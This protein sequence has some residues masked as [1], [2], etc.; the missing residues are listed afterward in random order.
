MGQ[1]A[2]AVDYSNNLLVVSARLRA[3]RIGSFLDRRTSCLGNCRACRLA[4]IGPTRRSIR[5]ACWALDMECRCRGCYGGDG[6]DHRTARWQL[7][8][9]RLARSLDARMLMGAHIRSLR[10]RAVALNLRHRQAGRFCLQCVRAYLRP[11]SEADALAHSRAHM[12]HRSR[13]IKYARDLGDPRSNLV[14]ERDHLACARCIS[15][16]GLIP[17]R[18]AWRPRRVNVRARFDRACSGHRRAVRDGGCGTIC[19]NKP[20]SP[21][22]AVDIHCSFSYRTVRV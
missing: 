2:F 18:R 19:R 1:R 11:V 13:S 9:R 7:A 20:R 21:T 15:E 10:F 22:L 8:K 5:S 3:L 17:S 12:A 16:S 4:V 6:P 14:A